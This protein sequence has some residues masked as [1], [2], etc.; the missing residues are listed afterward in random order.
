LAQNQQTPHS[1]R[2]Q[3]PGQVRLGLATLI[4]DSDSP[5]ADDKKRTAHVGESS[6]G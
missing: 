6:E 4:L 2:N 3:I 5:T 1:L